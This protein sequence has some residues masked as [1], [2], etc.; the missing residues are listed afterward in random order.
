M[1]PRLILN[2]IKTPDGTILTSR[3]VHDYVVYKDK[4]GL[5]YM[6]DGGNDYLRRNVHDDAPYTEMSL[7]TDSPFNEIRERICRGGRGKDGKQPLTWTPLCEMNDEWLKA[8]IQYNIDRDQDGY[9][10]ELY[11]KEMEYRKDN[12]IVINE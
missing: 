8:C 6:V 10:N 5:Q 9:M 11:R 2:Q 12:G 1:E 4:N 3:H 7:Y